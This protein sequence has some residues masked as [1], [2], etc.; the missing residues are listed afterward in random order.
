MTDARLTLGRKFIRLRTDPLNDEQQ[1][2][3]LMNKQGWAAYA[4]AAS[5][6]VKRFPFEEGATYPDYG[7]NVECFTAGSFIEIESLS[8]LRRLEPEETVE[9]VERWTLFPNFDAGA[10]EDS[11]A[12]A[13]DVVFAVESEPPAVAGG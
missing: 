2:I 13:L 5:L 11:L 1:K 10:T 7:C 9:H 3:G 8:P 12:A 4:R 6:F